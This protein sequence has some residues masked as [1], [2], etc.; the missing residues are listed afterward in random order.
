VDFIRVPLPAARTIA[1]MLDVFVEAIE[2]TDE[3]TEC[4]PP[5]Q[6][7]ADCATAAPADQSHL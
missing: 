7:R 2:M 1:A 3:I 4:A 5:S 6:G